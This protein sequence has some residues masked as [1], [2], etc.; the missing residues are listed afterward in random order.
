MAHASDPRATDNP[1][2]PL[3]DRERVI[4]AVRAAWR[5]GDVDL[6]GGVAVETV[7]RI[8]GRQASS[9]RPHLRDDGRVTQEWGVPTEGGK[10]RHSYRPVGGEV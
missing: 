5:A 2:A 10:P 8:V 6:G 4:T 7:A 1:G 3:I 9:V